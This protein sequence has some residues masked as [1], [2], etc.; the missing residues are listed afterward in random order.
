MGRRV[1]CKVPDHHDTLVIYRDGT[2]RY[3]VDRLKDKH[4]LSQWKLGFTE[5]GRPK[6]LYK[7]SSALEDNPN[8]DW[9]TDWEPEDSVEIKLGEAIANALAD[10]EVE[11]M[12]KG[13]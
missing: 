11:K 8:M 6:F 12:L 13:K 2:W 10:V 4:S 1:L 9:D 3:N 7:G 5:D